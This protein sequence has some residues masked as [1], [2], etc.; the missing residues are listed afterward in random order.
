MTCGTVDSNEGVWP[1]THHF[2]RHPGCLM[3]SD[4]LHQTSFQFEEIRNRTWGSKICK[5]KTW[6][7][8]HPPTLLH[9]VR[10]AGVSTLNLKLLT[11]A[12]YSSRYKSG[13]HVPARACTCHVRC[14]S[15]RY[16]YLIL[17]ARLKTATHLL[18]KHDARGV[19][20][21]IC[22]R[23]CAKQDSSL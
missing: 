17:A 15:R 22:S 20:T 21:P 3:L 1:S 2:A 6:S 19:W 4:K 13:W 10:S 16:P 5:L 12:V 23:C 11:R 14:T 7:P 9:S 8:T 18:Q